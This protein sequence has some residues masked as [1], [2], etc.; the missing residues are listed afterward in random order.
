MAHKINGSLN[1][2]GQILNLK[3]EVLAVDPVGGA[4]GT[5]PRLWVNST[6]GL[7]K[8]FN[9][10][11]T[12]GLGD[13]SGLV[14]TEQLAT[15]L[16]PYAQ[17]ADVTSAIS[18]AVAGLAS[19]QDVTDA[20]ANL[21]STATMTNAIE[22]A[23][24]GLDFQTDVVGLESEFAGVAGRYI[25][26]DG[27]EFATGVS[28]SA[29]DIV[30][31]DASGVIVSVA[32]DV[33]TA[34]AGALVWSTTAVKWL[35]WN[36]SDWSIFGGLSGVTADNGIQ[37]SGDTLSIKLDGA[38]LVVGP[39]GLKVGDLSA[40]YT[41]TAALATAIANFVTDTEMSDAIA[42]AV[43]GLATSQSVTEAVAGLAVATEVTEE[44]AAAVLG[45]GTAAA[46]TAVDDKVA[47]LTARIEASEFQFTPQEA[48]TT[49]TVTH[50]F[51][52]KYPIVQVV[53]TDDTVI[54]V[55][56]IKFVD[57]NSLT[58]KLAVAGTP[59]V[60]VQGLKAAV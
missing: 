46:I 38:T 27:T 14:S 51:G 56:E 53:D 2:L 35:R 36:G 31:V 9:G 26:E 52:N 11:T 58:V 50:N 42:A 6:S 39:N 45:L 5:A 12:I 19:E 1:V 20:V 17:T 8:F 47:A 22:N 43:L 16:V 7:L 34:G 33:S 44:I 54:G 30:V 60:I 4:L 3:P 59:K 57:V 32:Y 41:T 48:G 15:A 28:A 23:I 24:A 10:T 49:I 18:D 13:T 21:V 37:K 40:T 25:Y 29:G 55:D